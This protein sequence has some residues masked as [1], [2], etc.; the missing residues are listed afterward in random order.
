MT[1]FGD[2]LLRTFLIGSQHFVYKTVLTDCHT[3]KYSW[4][5]FPL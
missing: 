1:T 2:L 4:D 3:G 5:I